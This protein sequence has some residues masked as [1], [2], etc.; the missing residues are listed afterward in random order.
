[1]GGVT[2]P[3][4]SQPKAKTSTISHPGTGYIDITSSSVAGDAPRTDVVEPVGDLREAPGIPLLRLSLPQRLLFN[5]E[6]VVRT[7]PSERL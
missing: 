4:A 1:M 2:P 7:D 5:L 6:L 3:R